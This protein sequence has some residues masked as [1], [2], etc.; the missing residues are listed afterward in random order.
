M[1]ARFS[2]FASKIFLQTSFMFFYALQ[3]RNKTKYRFV[4]KVFAKYYS[5]QAISYCLIYSSINEYVILEIILSNVAFQYSFS[6]F[7]VT[8]KIKETP[9]LMLFLKYK[10]KKS[11]LNEMNEIIKAMSWKKGLIPNS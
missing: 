2:A 4:F 11:C 7:K 6:G 1:F 5:L 9:V 10:C 8:L 3:S